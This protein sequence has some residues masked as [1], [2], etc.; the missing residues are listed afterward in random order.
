MSEPCEARYRE[1]IERA[2]VGKLDR[3]GWTALRAHLLDCDACRGFYD[4]LG[5]VDRALA[6]AAAVSPMI[7][8]SIEA[9]VL[10]GAGVAEKRGAWWAWPALASAALGGVAALIVFGQ[11][12]PAEGFG[13]RG[14]QDKTFAGRAPGVAAFCVRATGG[15]AAPRISGSARGTT[16]ANVAALECGIEDE[17]QLA[18]SSPTNGGLYLAAWGEGQH[19]EIYWY[20]PRD[21]DAQILSMK[22]DAIDE[23]LPWSTRLSV[24]HSPGKVRLRIRFLDRSMVAEAARSYSTPL[25]EQTIPL[26]VKPKPE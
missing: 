8:D 2:F 5:A 4:R 13:V 11:P 26:E 14:T 3:E 17:I 6:P 12:P 22:S 25:A 10:A 19:G 24:K 7:R 16:D 20:A 1:Q 9:R 15:D 18:Y 21:P 23:P